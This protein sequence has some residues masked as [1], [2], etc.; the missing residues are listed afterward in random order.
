MTIG[1]NK[2]GLVPHNFGI[3]SIYPTDNS[4]NLTERSMLYI[5]AITINA[6]LRGA[7][8]RYE[9]AGHPSWETYK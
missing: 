5:C 4:T 7:E 8:G 9:K 3:G 6:E 1:I 2:V